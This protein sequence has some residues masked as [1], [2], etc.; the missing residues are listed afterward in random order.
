MY[1]GQRGGPA[2]ARLGLLAYEGQCD[3]LASLEQASLVELEFEWS[4]AVTGR[5]ARRR[6]C[7]EGRINNGLGLRSIGNRCDCVFSIRLQ[8][9]SL[10][11]ASQR[12]QI[13]RTIQN[14]HSRHTSL[15]RRDG[16]PTYRTQ[17]ASKWATN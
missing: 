17:S 5:R 10:K 8:H 15:G 12:V 14:R 4:E 1:E 13:G 16:G 7:R 9:G 3:S 2:D 6:H 11:P